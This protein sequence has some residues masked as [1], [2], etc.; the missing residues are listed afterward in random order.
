M[1]HS[2]QD[3]FRTL[4]GFRDILQ[5][6]GYFPDLNPVDK[7]VNR[8]VFIGFEDLV[9]KPEADLYF[10]VAKCI[11]V[12]RQTPNAFW[13]TDY[14][15]GLELIARAKIVRPFLERD[16]NDWIA[17]FGTGSLPYVFIDGN[18]VYYWYIFGGSIPWDYNA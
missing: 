6:P 13:M 15:L 8:R 1:A 4:R 2:R 16:V 11:M 10:I 17:A 3:L 9:L 12:Q 14:D 18:G 5:N 7:N